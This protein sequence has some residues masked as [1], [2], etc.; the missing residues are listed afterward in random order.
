VRILVVA[1]GTGGHFYPGLA[2]AKALQSDVAEV[3][4]VVRC[5]DMVIPLLEREQI[6][7]FPIFAA[8]FRRSLSPRNLLSILKLAAGTE[9]TSQSFANLYFC[10]R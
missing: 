7:A 3:R 9:S 1:G 10:R 4:F 2:V 5:G 6:K 8:G